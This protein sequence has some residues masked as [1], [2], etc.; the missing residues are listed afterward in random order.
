M[1]NILL[2]QK[3]FILTFFSS[4]FF[5]PA[6]GQLIKVSDEKQSFIIDNRNPEV[7]KF[8]TCLD[9]FQ[10]V[11]IKTKAGVFSQILVPDYGASMEEGKPQLPVLKH[12][13]EIPM[14]CEVE[15][16]YNQ[17][18]YRE[19]KLKDFNFNDPV[20]PAQ[21]PVSKQT[22][23]PAEL[24][25]VYDSLTYGTDGFYSLESVNVVDLGILRGVHLARLEISPFS[26]NPVTATFEIIYDLDAEIRFKHANF[27]LTETEKSR[28]F[29]PWFEAA[30]E[31]LINHK[32]PQDLQRSQSTPQTFI[33]V[34]DPLFQTPLQPF[35]QWKTR[36]GF[37]VVEAYTNNPSV[38]G[39]A[40]SIKTY[41]K[42]FYN[43]PPA[44]FLP[45]SFV[46]FVGDVAQIPSFPGNAGTHVTDLYYC[47]YTNDILPEVYYGRFS[48]NNL[49]ELQ[50]QIDKTLEY[51]QYLMPDPSFLDEV[52][53]AAGADASH[54]LT[55]GNGQ[56][57]YGT[58]NYFNEAHG[59]LSNTYLQPEPSGANYSGKIIQNIS[60][61]VAYAN[62][63]AHCGITGWSNPAFSSGNVS[64]LQNSHKY[65]LMV[66]N[67]CQSNSF[68]STCF[69]E[70]LLRAA[71][72]GA[73]GYIG[74]TDYTYWD[75]DY[76]WGVGFKAISSHPTY[77]SQFLGAY[78][79]TFHDK[80]GLTTDNWFITQGQMVSAGNL[81]VTQSGSSMKTYYWEIYHLMGDPSVMIYFS[82]P[83]AISVSYPGSMPAS[84]ENF[85]VTTE[86][87]AYVAISK[88]DVLYGAAF[89]D[90]SG[91]AVVP[92]NPITTPGM[93]DIVVTKQ[94]RKPFFGTIEIV[95][96]AI[97][98]L[99]MPEG[100]SGISTNMIPETYDLPSLL[101]PILNDVVILQNLDGIYEP[102]MNIN[103]IGAW[104]N[105]EGYQI[106][107][108]NSAALQISGFVDPDKEIG[109][110]AGWNLIP[111]LCDWD[112]DVLELFAEVT[113]N[114]E[115]VKEV[116]G[117]KVYWPLMGINT[118]G[119]LEPG[120]AYYV[121]TNDEVTITFPGYK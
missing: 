121:L 92:L 14:D 74:G 35:V 31:Q 100:W 54:Q 4:I 82:Q 58:E 48:A 12:L 3:A 52:V 87:Y 64:S 45:Q 38:G 55:W 39:T 33:I 112:V 84:A 44:G 6:Y 27:E 47:E 103:T 83:P 67:C 18:N 63:S 26:Y 106:K 76:W 56:I 90:L 88:N 104:D 22:D 65:P 60:D 97:Q 70:T 61:G 10:V 101:Q 72:K 110:H 75:E 108:T 66:G 69:G 120:K 62:Y 117:T 99:Y 113:G 114:I 36:K 46:L 37:K 16:V 53:M 95:Q 80:P 21:P 15:V 28:V 86:P 1:R 20:F 43:N 59:L 73:L 102:E 85:T 51:E 107:L 71:N 111:V 93:A 68:N 119:Y 32:M 78:D 89:A 23:D 29:S 50:P 96:P 57:N 79:R 40:T 81:A 11:E 105:H 8:H 2:F 30:F 9:E 94:N 49:T 7:L 77:N 116:A 98:F 41:L 109:L 13:I 5:M 91:I 25:F 118:L 24:V 17:Q 42:N 19:I 115:L 34:S